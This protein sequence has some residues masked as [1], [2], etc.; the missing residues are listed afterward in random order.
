MTFPVPNG[1]PPEPYHSTVY[2]PEHLA[3]LARL[4]AQRAGHGWA[5]AL[6]HQLRPA[7]GPLFAV[8]SG[9]EVIALSTELA[10][11]LEQAGPGRLNGRAHITVMAPLTPG[12]QALSALELWL[13]PPAIAGLRPDLVQVIL[14]A[15][16]PGVVVLSYPRRP[17]GWPL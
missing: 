1:V 5:V 13:R 17:P 6:T 12:P 4:A 9:G 16:I 8:T 10:W 11:A 7:Q 15:H 3:R 14:A 2:D